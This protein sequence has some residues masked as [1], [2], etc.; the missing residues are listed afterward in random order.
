MNDFDEYGVL[1]NEDVGFMVCNLNTPANNN[2]KKEENVPV[3]AIASFNDEIKRISGILSIDETILMILL[4]NNGWNLHSFVESFVADRK[5][6]LEKA[7]LK[8]LKSLSEK[9]FIKKVPKSSGCEI[10]LT[11]HK[12]IYELP[13][14]HGCCSACWAALLQSITSERKTFVTCQ[15]EG[16]NCSVP[17]TIFA[18]AGLFNVD[19]SLF[20]QQLVNDQTLLSKSIITCPNVKC[21]KILS[22][23]DQSVGKFLCPHCSQSIC[24]CCFDVEHFPLSCT[25]LIVWKRTTE[26]DNV[27]NL[28]TGY[29]IKKC[30]QCQVI[31]QK[32]KGCN[33]MSCF[34]CGYEFC[35][36]CGCKWD[37]DVKHFFNCN[38][39][40]KDRTKEHTVFALDMYLSK[41]VYF[42]STIA[43][44]LSIK[45]ELY[46]ILN[47][48]SFTYPSRDSVFN[49]LDL[50]LDEICSCM[51]ILSWSYA[52]YF[53]VS[54]EY[55][56]SGQS[57]ENSVLLC[58][59]K[60]LEEIVDYSVAYLRM[61]VSNCR[62]GNIHK[63]QKAMNKM[64]KELNVQKGLT[65]DLVMHA[66]VD[67]SVSRS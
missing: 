51:S 32:N 12:N 67:L 21:S 63:S 19:M 42:K 2:N 5:G 61:I 44:S 64:Y 46:I 8:S 58:S 56:N 43:S 24:M 17:L 54:V 26:T 14:G 55:I 59:M 16:C 66:K 13:C 57:H 48:T 52:R 3:D 33:H 53:F 23:L 20:N 25:E 34:A 60:R 30:P 22:N 15:F 39:E 38:K 1:N 31:I 10:C 62:F 9:L 6:T 50:L 7:G 28:R 65:V 36:G 37:K 45:E 47:Q 41:H 40:V 18:S 27:I 29:D 11:E 35:W 4:K 49:T